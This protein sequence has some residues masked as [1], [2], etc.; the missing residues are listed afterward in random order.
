VDDSG[1][2]REPLEYATPLARPPIVGLPPDWRR[3]GLLAIGAAAVVFV[4]TF[5]TAWVQQRSSA[6]FAFGG[7]MLTIDL[8]ETQAEIDRYT[9]TTGAPPT[10]LSDVPAL[11]SMRLADPWRRPYLLKTVNGK[12]VIFSYG[13]DGVPGGDGIDADVASAPQTVHYL[14]HRQFIELMPM[15]P[16]LLICLIAAGATAMVAF[17]GKA[18][19]RER[20]RNLIAVLITLAVTGAVAATVGGM[21]AMLHIPSGH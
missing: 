4:L 9:T 7:M 6:W 14:T 19:T 1:G 16:L 5:E 8:K 21:I 10:K 3:R 20:P 11:Q 12:A 2:H 15:K 18:D 13:R 17:A